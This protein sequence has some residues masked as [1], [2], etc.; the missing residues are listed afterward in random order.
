MNTIFKSRDHIIMV[1][2]VACFD[3]FNIRMA[4]G[5]FI[6]EAIDAVDQNA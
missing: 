4:G 6:S 2:K 3:K 1:I 5:N